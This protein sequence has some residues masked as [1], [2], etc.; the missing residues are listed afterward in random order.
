ML[1]EILKYEIK[2][3]EISLHQKKFTFNFNHRT[4]DGWNWH[5]GKLEISIAV[6]K[7]ENQLNY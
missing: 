5:C 2:L 4:W 6:R 7:K 3:H 1:D